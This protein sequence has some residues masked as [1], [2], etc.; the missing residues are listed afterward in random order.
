MATESSPPLI[1]S[2]AVDIPLAHL[3]HP[4]DY[5]V[6]DIQ[7][8][9]V[10]VGCR[11]RV[12]FAGRL[13]DGLV[14]ALGEHTQAVGELAYLERVV[15]SEVVLTTPIARLLRVVADHYAGTWADVA[16]LAIPPRHARTEAALPAARPEP[17][18]AEPPGVLSGYGRGSEFLSGLAAGR[19]VRAVWNPAPVADFAG[20]WAGGILDA[21]LATLRVGRGSIIVV[22]DVADV[23]KVAKRVGAAIGEP[24]LVTLTSDL[25]PA[26][27]YRHFLAILRG[28]VRVV[29]G[30]RAAIF[31][32]VADLG[33]IAVWDEG[34]DLLAEPRAP[35][36]HV[37]EVAAL[38]AS[39]EPCGLLLA[40]WSRTAQTQALVERNWLVPL[41]LPP[42]QIRQLSPVVRV[43]VASDHDLERDPQA[44]T[45]RLPHAVFA[46]I[47]G[48]LPTGPVLI[49]VP[50]AGYLTSL[51]CQ[52]CR[53][54]AKCPTC[55]RTLSGESVG[56]T[57]NPV[58]AW[59]G[60]LPNGWR[61]VH[62]GSTRLRAPGV[63]VQRT[64]E[65][66]GRAFPQTP[67]VTSWAGHVVE[68][69]ADHP[70]LV[71]STPGAEPVADAGYAAAVLLDTQVMLG[72]PSLAAAEE[73]L[74]RWLA[75]CSLVRS[76]A[77]GGTVTAVGE[78]DSRALQALIRLDAAGFA[79][80]ELADRQAAHLPPAARVA[81][82][83]G[84]ASA[85]AEYTAAW[86]PIETVAAFGPVELSDG[87]VRLVLRTELEHGLA[88]VEAIRLESA[89]RARRKAPGV[90]RVRVD[91][92]ELG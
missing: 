23:E 33:L 53:T 85:V 29:V 42:A 71:L 10:A 17:V 74:R 83:T 2:V 87:D 6:S 48:A 63:G 72:R 31:A 24:S 76:A 54:Q 52:Q 43:A 13:R 7:R 62:C 68:R 78:P 57:I 59:C 77:N 44:A 4:F 86:R 88:L 35:Y 82:L 25:G 79:A 89:A 21:V 91:P 18:L 66:L 12:R 9:S 70:A 58:C 47:R 27:R 38:R 49:Q 67:V 32:P 28:Q 19:P 30:T 15:S 61:C 92:I 65:E 84:A 14:L 45:V 50:R 11:V 5:L 26:R 64:A 8:E 80:R 75:V 46:A 20:D 3:D 36:H 16:R 90:V 81:E 60:P 37:R 40:G 22:P 56:T 73:A 1:A 41:E 55:G 51:A 69:V 34:N 39:M